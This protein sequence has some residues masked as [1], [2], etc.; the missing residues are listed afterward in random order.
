MFFVDL[1]CVNTFLLATFVKAGSQILA[2]RFSFPFVRI[3]RIILGVFFA[4]AIVDKRNGLSRSIFTVKTSALLGWVFA[5]I[6]RDVMPTMSGFR[7]HRS[8]FLVILPR[9]SL[10]PLDLFNG[11]KPSQTAKAL[12]V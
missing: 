2:R 6:A 8:P 5:R 10:P 3:V 9:R 11:V 1:A 7:M 12:P 4:I